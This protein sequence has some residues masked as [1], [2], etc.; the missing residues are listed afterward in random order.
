MYLPNGDKAIVPI[1]K[2]RDYCLNISH[3]EGKHRAKVFASALGMTTDDAEDLRQLLLAAAIT[4]EVR[5]GEN[6]AHGQRYILDFT[7]PGLYGVVAIRSSWIV[8]TGQI[9]P[10]LVTC[11]V[12]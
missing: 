5:L 3:I 11:Y 10:R 6:N 9:V 12:N 1:E 4:E 2:L 7:T 8:R